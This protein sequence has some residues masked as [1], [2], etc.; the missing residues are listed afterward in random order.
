MDQNSGLLYLIKLVLAKKKQLIIITVIAAISGTAIAFLLPVY[1][2]ST[3]IFYPYSPKTYDPRYMFSNAGDIELF[4]SGDD[5]DRIVTIGESSFITNY[6]IQ[7]YNLVDRYKINREDKYYYIKTAEEF[8][9]NYIIAEDDRSAITV[10]IYDKDAD[11]AAIIANDIVEQIDLSNR[12]PLIEGTAKQLDKFKSDLQI[13]YAT[14]DSLSKKS[15]SSTKKLNDSETDMVSLEM[16]EAYSNMQEAE[17]R[18]SLLKQD[19]KTLHIIEKAAPVIK[20]A[21]PVRWLIISGS[22]LGTLFL[23]IVGLI[24]FEQYQ[25]NIKD[26]L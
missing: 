19:F 13:K 10:T 1:Y 2:K 6:I 9:D 14:L 7:K 21:R 16:I 23:Y 5:A 18:L 17:T 22:V 11:T 15:A 4:G 24:L 25:K 20:K 26:N 8:K 12:R 3:S